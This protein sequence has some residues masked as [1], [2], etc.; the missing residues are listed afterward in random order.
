MLFLVS[1]P[2]GNLGDITFRAVETLRSCDLILCEDT[3]HSLKLLQHYDI[4][5]PLKSYHKFNQKESKEGLLEAWAAGKKIALIT[6]AGTPGI[7][8]P[9]IEL[10]QLCR[11]QG[12]PITAIPGPCAAI[13]ALCCAGFP[14]DRFQFWGFLP[15]KEEELQRTLKKILTYEGTTICY[16]SP[17][18]VVHV[19]KALA[20]IAPDR[21]IAVG[22]ELTKKFEEVV[23]GKA[24]VLQTYWQ[25]SHPK[26]EIVLLIGPAE[27]AVEVDWSSLSPEE[28]VSWM[29]KAY[30]LSRQ[31]AIKMVAQLRGVPKRV[32][33]NQTTCE[34][35]ERPPKSRDG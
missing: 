27:T 35:N 2:I 29:E 18:R 20:A 7:S 5:K 12:I 17:L 9:G 31:E 23:S 13:Q 26:G 33:Y 21:D 8:D 32:I 14:T 3:R 22:R 28:H 6:D 15:K 19:V 4:S 16:E 34:A 11:E 1:T 30:Y 25:D 10:V 24:S